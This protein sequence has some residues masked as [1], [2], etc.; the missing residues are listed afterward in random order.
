MTILI[1]CFLNKL[2]IADMLLFWYRLWHQFHFKSSSYRKKEQYHSL[3]IHVH[4]LSCL[5]GQDCMQ[6]TPIQTNQLTNVTRPLTYKKLFTNI[7]QYTNVTHTITDT[8][9]THKRTNT[10]TQT[11]Q[12]TNTNVHR[13][14]TTQKRINTRT[15]THNLHT[16]QHTYAYQCSPSG[17]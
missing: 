8:K 16:H 13:H 2:C 4:R 7:I 5:D 3:T 1:I 6:R 14:K 15:Q 17:T 9:T 11:Y 10:R 12:H